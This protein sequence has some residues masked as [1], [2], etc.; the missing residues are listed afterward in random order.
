MATKLFAFLVGGVIILYFA[1]E[2]LCA[3]RRVSW[4]FNPGYQQSGEFFPSRRHSSLLFATIRCCF[5]SC[6]SQN[7]G[8]LI[9]LWAKKLFFPS[10]SSSQPAS[11]QVPPHHYQPAPVPRRLSAKVKNTNYYVLLICVENFSFNSCSWRGNYHPPPPPMSMNDDRIK[12]F[13]LSQKVRRVWR[14]RGKWA[15]WKNW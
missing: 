7:H 14:S 15:R 1:W 2:K 3:L 8:N 9:L 12:F 10:S 5:I 13:S 6:E 4:I 11:P